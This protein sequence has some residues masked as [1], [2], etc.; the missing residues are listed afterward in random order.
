MKKEEMYAFHTKCCK[1]F[2]N[3]KRIEILD[4]LRED[5]MTVNAI[6]EEIGKI[7]AYT[8]A[9]LSVMRMKNIVKARRD[10]T[11]VNYALQMRK[12]TMPAAPCRTSLR[13]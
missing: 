10:G 7:K 9:L 12:S 13:N 4:L 3:P 8:S 6:Q 2:T 5:E 1:T 11:N